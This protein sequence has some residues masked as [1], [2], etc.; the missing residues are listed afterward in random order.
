MLSLRS[1]QKHRHEYRHEHRHEHRRGRAILQG[2]LLELLI[3]VALA[4]VGTVAVLGS[5]YRENQRLGA[6]DV[7]AQL[8]VLGRFSRAY[9]SNYEPTIT[10]ALTASGAATNQKIILAMRGNA[11]A[12]QDAGGSPETAGNITS[13]SDAHKALDEL[14]CLHD[15]PHWDEEALEAR[16]DYLQDHY[17]L[18]A[19]RGTPGSTTDPFTIQM[20]LFTYGGEEIPTNILSR[21]VSYTGGLGG[22]IST[23]A[24]Y[25]T[26]PAEIHGGFGSW[27]LAETFIPTSYRGADKFEAGHLAFNLGVHAVFRGGALFLSREED[28]PSGN[29]MERNLTIEG[30]SLL[31]TDCGDDHACQ[32]KVW[33]IE[34]CGDPGDTTEDCS[35][36]EARRAATPSDPMNTSRT[37]WGCPND[38]GKSNSTCTNLRPTP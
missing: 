32:I 13:G 10:L 22:F 3:V 31:F 7:A 1:R 23:D 2:G 19:R 8:Q 12:A 25:N 4:V 33:K 37:F 21:I 9:V 26:T 34:L 17:L 35:V 5:L 18:L 24:P 27:T 14:L 38:T 20:L 6:Q 11:C 28:P 36:V 15:T 16:N 30:K 29:T